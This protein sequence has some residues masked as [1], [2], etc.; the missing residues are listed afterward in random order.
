MSSPT[1]AAPSAS[2]AGNLSGTGTTGAGT[3]TDAEATAGRNANSNALIRLPPPPLRSS[4]E[5]L[6][7]DELR[8][9]LEDRGLATNGRKAE[10]VDRLL[11]AMRD[12]WLA[13]LH[14][15]HNS[16]IELLA[17]QQL[18]ARDDD[19][20]DD[21]DDDEDEE[22]VKLIER[23][24]HHCD[25]DRR[26]RD[27]RIRRELLAARQREVREDDSQ[28]D[29]SSGDEFIEKL[30]E[31]RKMMEDRR[32]EA[33]AETEDAAR[34]RCRATGSSGA[35]KS[36][37]QRVQQEDD[38]DLSSEGG[39]DSDDSSD[40]DDD[41]SNGVK[42]D[43]IMERLKRTGEDVE[44]ARMILREARGRGS[45][46]SDTDSIDET[47][48]KLEEHMDNAK[49]PR[50]RRRSGDGGRGVTL[51]Q[52]LDNLRQQV[53]DL[54]PLRQEVA[55]LRAEND[56]QAVDIHRLRAQVSRLQGE[57]DRE[58]NGD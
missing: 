50:S 32:A 27:V 43:E 57:G 5:R 41:D 17:A 34:S 39:Q 56:L 1:S 22:D 7:V 15:S 55:D 42:Y 30:E 13:K 45:E 6:L 4:I 58:T 46:T 8:A 36:T 9:K 40:D 28:D 16:L 14:Q 47:F 51:R 35:G 54:L 48:R 52:E 10:L 53:T 31:C 24:E 12:E 38:G 37:L 21:D 49:A 26:R 3:G 20:Q 11:E 2:A 23:E 18:K 44:E 29:D 33:E 19:S 25:L